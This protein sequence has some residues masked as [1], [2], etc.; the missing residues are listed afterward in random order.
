[1]SPIGYGYSGTY[2]RY[3]DVDGSLGNDGVN[4]MPL[5]Y[6]PVISILSSNRIISGSGSESEP[7]I[8]E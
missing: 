6:R 8:I 5:G 2:V 1:M 7:W 3:V 4:N